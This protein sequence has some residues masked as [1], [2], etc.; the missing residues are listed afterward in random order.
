MTVR[1]GEQIKT[2]IYGTSHGPCIGVRIEGLPAGKS[3][4]LPKLQ[5]FLER[6]AP[7]RNA[8]S[9]PR[10]EADRP[11]FHSGVE[12][13]SEQLLRTTGEVLTA[14]IRNTNVRPQDYANA[15]V[16]PRPGHADYPAWVKYGRIES[17]GG[18]F[19]ARL[20]AALCIAGGIFL[21]WLEERGIGI[22]AHIGEIAGIE[23]EALDPM[24]GLRQDGQLA[25]IDPEFP[26]IDSAAGERMKEKIA[27]AK[28]AG[29]S[30]GGIVECAVTGVPAGIGSPIFGSIESRLCQTVFAVPAVKGIEFGA[31]FGVANMKGSENNDPFRIAPAGPAV[32]TASNH[33]GGILGGLSSGM[34]IIFRTA[35]KPTPSIALEQRSVDLASK[36]ETPLTVRGRHDPCIVPRAVPCIEAA[37]A[38]ALMDLVLENQRPVPRQK[39]QL[40]GLGPQRERIDAIDRQIIELME[41]RFD[42]VRE[43]IRYK[44]RKGMP[45]L[46][47]AREQA[48]LEALSG[49]CE[50]GK[51][52]YIGEILKK[53]MEESRRYQADHPL[54]YGLL[55][56]SLGHSHSPELHRLLADYEYGLFEREPDQ[57][58]AFFEED[59]WRGLNV[60]IPYKRDVMEYCDTLSQEAAA[61]GS[62]N[63]V[64]RRPA[65]AGGYEIRGEN[66][67]YFGFRYVVCNSG[68][69]PSGKKTLVLGSGGVSGTVCQVMR[70]LGADP[71]II[72]SRSGED[73]YDNLDRHADAAIIVNATPVGM[74]PKAGNSPVSLD[75]FLKL[76]VVYD[77]VY[78]PLRTKL[79]LEAEARGIPSFGGLAMLTAQAAAAAE[80]FAQAAE[81]GG[82][83]QESEGPRIPRELSRNE[84]IEDCLGKLRTGLES[85][86]LIGMPG[87]GKSTAGKALAE[88]TGRTLIDLDDWIT[89][90]A[91]RSP[92]EIIREDGVDVFRKTETEA[93]KR[94]VREEAAP[95]S[96]V[97]AAGGGI[98]EREENRELLRE[99]GRVFW[100]KRALADLPLDGRPVSQTDGVEAIYRRRRPRYEAWCDVQVEEGSPEKAAAAI[101]KAMRTMG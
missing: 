83:E 44:E 34:P 66:T 60:T 58:D 79:M 18:P 88:L 77:L 91:G 38:L 59:G 41:D 69:D 100:L 19:S 67:D 63:T 8:W 94:I 61:C 98:V 50:E 5:A 28:A 97:I 17:G 76:E 78:N 9:T 32:E 54:R 81:A 90:Y 65:G 87:A 14:E 86:V 31:G 25:K 39:G 6:R 36:T 23:D 53:M 92:E 89:E 10:K 1:F 12:N 72:I 55:G 93:L 21:Q 33:H 43:V 42:V 56:R 40:E 99:N 57:L 45:I 37:A 80:L 29:D 27:E 49:L 74:Y 35:M 82:F 85:I 84:W 20:T 3:I 22:A 73:N 71:V 30:I 2:E 24:P 95:G 75:G 26:V 62:V 96:L 51:E 68:I 15:S 16:V 52:V 46:D 70:D 11:V 4:D 48:K 64:V 13:V 101:A 7:G 47:A